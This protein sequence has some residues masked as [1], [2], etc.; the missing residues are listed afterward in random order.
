[1]D[2]K[3][4]KNEISNLKAYYKSLAEIK[5][6]I[7]KLNYDLTGVK[8]V[9]FD[10]QPA[11]YNQ[12]LS[13]WYRLDLIEKI[14]SK[15]KELDYTELAIKRYEANLK[16]LPKEIRYAVKQI[17]INGETF[18]E[19]GEKLGYTDAGLHYVIKKEIE[20]L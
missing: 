13:E 17:F 20:K 6:E 9:R 2:Y 8:G 18:A 4:F 15:E 19:T 7:E 16:R 3:T 14:E 11:S 10:R 5:D 12:S 1:M